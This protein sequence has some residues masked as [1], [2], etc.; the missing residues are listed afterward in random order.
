MYVDIGA[1][2]GDSATLNFDFTGSATNR[3]W[4]IKVTQIDCRAGNGY[5]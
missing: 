1:I 4:E 5:V 3:Q 2:E